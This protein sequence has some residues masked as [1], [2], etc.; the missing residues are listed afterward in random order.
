MLIE[1]EVEVS[2]NYNT[3]KFYESLGYSIPFIINKKGDKTLDKNKKIIVAICDLPEKSEVKVKCYCDYCLSK[4]VETIVVKMYESYL[5]C[6]RDA[7]IHKDCCN[8]CSSEKIKES[9]ILTYGKENVFQLEEIKEK[10]RESLIQIY[11]ETTAMRDIDVKNK[12]IETCLRKYGETN[13]TKTDE[14]KSK[15]AETCF[16]KY[17]VSSPMKTE[18]IRLMFSGV[19]SHF[20]RDGVTRKNSK[21]RE[22]FGYKSWKLKVFKRDN[23]TCQCCGEKTLL[24]AHHIINFSNNINERFDISNGITLCKN[25]HSPSVE[26]SFHYLNGIKDNTEEQLRYYIKLMRNRGGG[27]YE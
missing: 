17:G 2:L 14:Y 20:W 9:N 19:N 22:S 16:N 7:K 27:T 18:K 24:Q 5:R 15:T 26:G 12:V 10:I 6:N 3:Y 1:E 21:S 25:C 11:G 23:Y 13:Y 8:K 4:G